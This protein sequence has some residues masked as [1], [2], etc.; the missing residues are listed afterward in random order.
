MNTNTLGCISK[1]DSWSANRNPRPS[2][3]QRKNSF[4]DI[5]AQGPVAVLSAYTPCCTHCTHGTVETTSSKTKKNIMQGSLLFRVEQLYSHW[6]PGY[7][8]RPYKSHVPC[9][10]VSTKTKSTIQLVTIAKNDRTGNKQR[11]TQPL[12]FPG[13]ADIG[14]LTRLP[15]IDCKV[16]QR[17]LP[18]GAVTPAFLTANHTTQPQKNKEQPRLVVDRFLE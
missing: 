11:T 4:G 7:R 2:R 12:L 6:S 10:A 15:S 1:L 9:H 14:T 17:R 5:G 18:R 13:L 16:S 3:M 8:G